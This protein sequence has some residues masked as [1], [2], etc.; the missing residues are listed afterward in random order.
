MEA[1]INNNNQIINL[2]WNSPTW[3][4]AVTYDIEHEVGNTREIQLCKRIVHNNKI[5]IGEWWKRPS[6]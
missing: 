6:D 4:N 3:E 2:S 1:T 5:V